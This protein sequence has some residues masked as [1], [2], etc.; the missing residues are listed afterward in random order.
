MTMFFSVLY[1]EE[2]IELCRRS[3]GIVV[4]Q[5]CSYIPQL[6]IYFP[7]L[8]KDAVESPFQFSEKIVKD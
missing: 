8:V 5:R 2:R 4:F 3:W 6:V 1:G 7:Y